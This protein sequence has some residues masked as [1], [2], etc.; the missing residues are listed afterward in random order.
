VGDCA[1]GS[2]NLVC[3][4]VVILG[5]EGNQRIV[6]SWGPR[7]L[8]ETVGSD[9]P[10][11]T[12]VAINERRQAIGVLGEGADRRGFLWEAGTLH[13]IVSSDPT[14]IIDNVVD[15]NDRGQIAAHARNTST[16]QVGPVL[17]NPVP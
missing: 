4:G 9:V 5:A 13:R 3:D 11:G 8:S 7:R 15:I 10:R 2:A 12:F 16:G 14:W 6:L 17:L 1:G